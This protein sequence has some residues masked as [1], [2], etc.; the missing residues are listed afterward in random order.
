LLAILNWARIAI[1]V[2]QVWG[3]WNEMH[4]SIKTLSVAIVLAGLM[5][6]LFALQ[7]TPENR[8]VL[9]DRLM[10]TFPIQDFWVP[11]ERMMQRNIQNLPN[12]QR[13]LM[14]TL[15]VS[16]LRHMNWDVIGQA[17]RQTMI[18]IYSADELQALIAA[19]S[20]PVGRSYLR[21]LE[22][23]ESTGNLKAAE[24]FFS[25][26]VGQSIRRKGLIFISKIEPVY[27]QEMW[28]AIF[29]VAKEVS[30][31]DHRIQLGTLAVPAPR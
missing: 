12:N 17:M 21:N 26:P 23:Y 13:A 10:R 29:I 7:D 4:F 19:Y 16:V 30:N 25:S 14:R 8:A 3:D 22:S 24:A 20:S 2:N 27:K 18:E 28:T 6:H 9:T 31:R 11:V 5:T 15:V 1:G